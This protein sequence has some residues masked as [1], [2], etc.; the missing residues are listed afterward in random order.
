MKTLVVIL[1]VV[2]CGAALEIP[3][4]LEQEFI[5]AVTPF[6]SI[7]ECETNVDPH[8]AYEL[9]YN[10]EFANDACLKC[11]IKCL[12]F[13]LDYVNP[14]Y[15]PNFDAVANSVPSINITVPINCYSQQNKTDLCQLAFD[16]LKCV[17]NYYKL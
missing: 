11:F 6:I 13:K 4:E 12:F 3:C 2:I 15:S 7:C 1:S 17:V 5:A 9:I 10:L 14:D 16:Q 8:L